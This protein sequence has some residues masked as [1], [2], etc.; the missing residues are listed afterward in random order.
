MRV[1]RTVAAELVK[2]RGLPAVCATVIGTIAAA[3][4]LTAAVAASSA[5]GVDAVQATLATIPFLQV[6]PILLG[7]LAV[8]TEYQGSQLRTTLTTTPNR[9]LLLT[10]KTIAYTVTATLTSAATIATGLTTAAIT[11]TARDSPQAGT[12]NIWP[13]AGAGL[14]LVL[15]GLLGFALTVLLRSL[16]PPLV[17][18]LALVLIVS[19][20]L[21]S[22]EHSRWLPDRAGRL[23]YLPDADSLLTPETGSLVLL[24]WI[25][26][27]AITATTAFMT[28]DA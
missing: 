21:N 13:V 27:T 17:I 10:G 8:A 11:L 14:Y 20:L 24:T 1:M 7:V 19:P 28:R 12:V 22:T 2:L 5:D 4:A 25:T 18:M 6:G 26:L 15:I 16:V 3:I 23:L 9:G